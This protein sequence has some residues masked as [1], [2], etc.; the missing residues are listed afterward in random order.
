M[1]SSGGSFEENVQAGGLGNGFAREQAE[2][3]KA[4]PVAVHHVV[5]VDVLAVASVAATLVALF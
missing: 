2:P 1:E 3:V 5:L 4:T